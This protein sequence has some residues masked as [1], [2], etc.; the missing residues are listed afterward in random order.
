MDPSYVVPIIPNNL[1]KHETIIRIAEVLDHLSKVADSILERVSD[2]INEGN[3]KM[4]EITRRL[5]EVNSK[6]ER[7]SKAKS[8][9]QV[10]S[11]TKYLAENVHR[12]YTSIFTDLKPIKLEHHKVKHRKTETRE[13]PLDKLHIYHF[14]VKNDDFEKKRN[15]TWNVPPDIEYVNDV[16]LYNTGK[17]LYED[18]T[19][20][21]SMS[22]SKQIGEQSTE[23]TSEIEPAPYSISQRANMSRSA[24]HPYIYT[25]NLGEVPTLDVP[26]DLPDLPGIADDLRYEKESGPTIAPSNIVI[27]N[28]PDFTSLELEQNSSK[29]SSKSAGNLSIPADLPEPP[30]EEVAEKEQNKQVA[31]EDVKP[32]VKP[33][34]AAELNIRQEEIENLTTNQDHQISVPRVTL[35]NRQVASNSIMAEKSIGYHI[36]VD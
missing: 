3:N 22:V 13:E 24:N 31:S 19:M 8:A 25:P 34:I 26:L 5:E 4:L 1:R 36:H 28:L 27:S 18:L 20:S 6:V 21:D 16:L 7:L 10:F 30:V 32:K 35:N 2:R 23:D 17:N 29:L 15:E 14:K 11:S 9:T 12:K 33:G